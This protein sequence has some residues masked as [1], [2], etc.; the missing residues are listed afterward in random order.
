MGGEVVDRRGV[1][2]ETKPSKRWRGANEV[3][4]GQA[5]AI[6]E[7]IAPDGGDAIGNCDAGQGCAVLERAGVDGGDAVGDLDAGEAGALLE[8]IGFDGGEAGGDRD[9]G[10][11]GAFGERAGA[12]V[13][14]AGGELETGDT[15]AVG[16]RGATDGCQVGGERDAGEAGALG[17]RGLPDEF[18]A[19]RDSYAG[20]AGA[21]GER[22]LIDCNEVGGERDTGDAG[23]LRER[24]KV[25]EDDGVAA[26]GVWNGDVAP[27]AGVA[28]DGGS[29][30]GDGVGVVRWIGGGGEARREGCGGEKEDG[31]K[32]GVVSLF[33]MTSPGTP[34]GE[35]D[36]VVPF[37]YVRSFWFH[38]SSLKLHRF[39]MWQGVD[40]GAKCLNF[41]LKIDTEEQHVNFG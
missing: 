40:C 8:R 36:I 5:G 6:V 22:S 35:A 11:A 34:P 37:D 33:H 26:Q 10:E 14:E 27:R 30:G 17:E 18:E 32:A 16:K 4:P 9:A 38:P 12:D 28:G 20:E 41:E 24:V 2:V 25:D 7:C 13:S 39:F 23:V 3:H 15:S 29:L 19:G 1:G 31:Q 21:E